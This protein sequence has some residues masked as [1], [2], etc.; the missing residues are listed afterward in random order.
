LTDRNGMCAIGEWICGCGA[1]NKMKL[2]TK[3]CCQ[4]WAVVV[5]DEEYRVMNGL[6][7][8]KSTSTCC[9]DKW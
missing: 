7:T 4:L 6:N 2:D 5:D 8:K 1:N 9:R 3:L